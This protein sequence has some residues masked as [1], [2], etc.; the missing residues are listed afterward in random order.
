M[1][2]SNLVEDKVKNHDPEE[3]DVN[4]DAGG[5]FYL[6][7]NEDDEDMNNDFDVRGWGVDYIL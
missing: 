7:S 6:M 4:K 5:D 2:D 3:C 1:E